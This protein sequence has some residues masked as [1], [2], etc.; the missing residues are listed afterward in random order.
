MTE[1]QLQGERLEMLID[2]LNLT[3][4]TFSKKV[5][6]SQSYVNRILSGEKSLSHKVITNITTGFT[7]VNVNWLLTGIGDMFLPTSGDTSDILNESIAVYEKA[8]TEI[9]PFEML[10][11]WKESFEQ[12]FKDLEA[13]VARMRVLLEGEGKGSAG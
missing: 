7:T 9:E 5:K 1:K 8:G 13:E 2:A 12:R 3:Q 6:V 4:V 10:R 11:L